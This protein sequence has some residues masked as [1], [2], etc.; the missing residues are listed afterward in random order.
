MGRGGS[1][2]GRSGRW[3][4]NRPSPPSQN[5]ATDGLRLGRGVGLF[6]LAS[7]RVATR[8]TPVFY[9][10]VVVAE[11][12]AAADDRGHAIQP[13]L[14]DRRTLGVGGRRIERPR[15]IVDSRGAGSY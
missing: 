1:P 13:G 2:G 7:N 11:R 12:T 8:R 14:V 15:R 6:V 4:R 10:L 5:G 9:K 3:G